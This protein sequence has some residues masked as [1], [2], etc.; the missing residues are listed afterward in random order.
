MKEIQE[1]LIKEVKRIHAR[2]IV[3][4]LEMDDL[5]KLESLTKSWKTYFGSEIDEAKSDL[6]SLSLDE[7]RAIADGKD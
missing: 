6:A 4:E 7:L 1:I 2:A 5:K 3:A